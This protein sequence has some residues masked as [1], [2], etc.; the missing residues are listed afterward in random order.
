[1]G[2]SLR[3]PH[4]RQDL[5]KPRFLVS[6][7]VL[8]LAVLA[9]LEL[10]PQR[11]LELTAPGAVGNLFLTVPEPTA[12]GARAVA[13]VDAEHLHWRCHYTDKAGYH[14]CGLTLV[15]SGDDAT[16]GRDLR[17][18]DSLE[19]DLRY[20][21]PA[22]FV[23]V[24][25][26]NFDPRFS[27]AEDG[28]SARI[29]SLNL[30]PRDITQPV[31]I[32]LAELTVPEWWTQQY[33][34]ARDYIRPS[35]ENVTTLTVDVPGDLVGQV[36]E[37]QLRRLALK[38]EWVSRD[39]VYLA[40]LALWLVAASAVAARGWQRLRQSYSRQQREID[41]LTARARVLRV[42]QDQLRRLATIDELTGVLNRRGLEQALDDFEEACQ[43]LTVLLMDIDHF[44]HVNDRHG[45]DCGDE[46]L[47]RVASVIV[48]NLRASD[49]F[50]RWGGEE[51][52]IACKG[53]RLRDAAR[54]ADKLRERIERAE[55]HTS[56]GRIGVTASFGVALAP[57]GLPA[58]GAVKRADNA[59]YAAKEAGRNRVE[60]DQ[61]LPSDAPT[62]V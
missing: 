48:S 56:A 36:H 2:R 60:V 49:V 30:R 55:I 50:G 10:L 32:D 62:T 40:V 57:P 59:L 31:H 9:G 18:F 51:F 58:A 26:R 45:H 23:R 15:L 22:P 13:W 11:Q 47:R 42:E 17:R 5:T 1:M 4:V 41:A 12:A 34:L 38:G 27:K 28:N 20:R 39:Q 19:M 61:S 44:K 7:I 54:L 33:D 25:L 21:G 53:T 37:L 35:V 43:G 46:V 6:G 24:A 29:Q 14:A 3:P 16:R 8:T 52:L